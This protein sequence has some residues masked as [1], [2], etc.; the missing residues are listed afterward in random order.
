VTRPYDNDVELSCIILGTTR[1]PGVVTLS[2]HD[3][4][5][6]WEIKAA[7][8]Q[9]GASTSLNGDPVGEFDASFFLA[10]DGDNGDGP[11]D[12][13]RWE[14]FQ[15]LLE[16]CV[17]GP[18]PTALPIYHPDLSRNHFTEVTVGKIGGMVHDGKGGATVKVHFLEYRPP[19][20]KPA[21]KAQ[22]KPYGQTEGDIGT[23]RRV[24]EDPNAAAKREL[25]GLVEEAKKP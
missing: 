16:S 23:G 20:P 2:G 21:A 4:A 5:K 1:S 10:D 25:A 22:S 17:N 9:T 3:R 7:K 13:D 12:F 14:E 11:G 15:R 6:A 19:K 18:K 24:S 8:G